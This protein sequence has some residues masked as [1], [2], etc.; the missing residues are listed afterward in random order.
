MSYFYDNK[1]IAKVGSLVFDISSEALDVLESVRSGGLTSLVEQDAYKVV[2]P[3]F[4]VMYLN[5][6]VA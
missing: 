2:T 6:S 3:L 4:Q 5:D 1:A